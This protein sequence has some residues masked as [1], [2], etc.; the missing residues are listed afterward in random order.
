MPRV[1]PRVIW[2]GVVLAVL[3][4]AVAMVAMT[5]LDSNVWLWIGLG[6]VGVGVGL[7]WA[8]G[9]MRDVRMHPH[10]AS[11]E[12]SEVVRGEAHSGVS[13]LSDVE[14]FVPPPPAPASANA[15]A[16]EGTRQPPVPTPARIHWAGL[17]M[18]LLGGWMVVSPLLLFYPNAEVTND[19]ILR[20]YGF[21]AVLVVFGLLLRSPHRHAAVAAVPAVAGSAL[22]LAVAVNEPLTIRA[23]V[24]D[25][26]AGIL[27]LVLAAGHVLLRAQLPG[28][29][30]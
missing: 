22:L 6:L 9:I 14:G 30:Q 13:A 16:A 18:V 26:A 20:D 7:G 12:V 17:A 27:A 5:F 4:M 24:N 2:I 25:I 19:V 29:R 10:G 21:A 3:G 8:F 11:V 28:G 15:G 1:R 23:T